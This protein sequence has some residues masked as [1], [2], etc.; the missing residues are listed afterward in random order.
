MADVDP[1][2]YDGP[3]RRKLD[4]VAAYVRAKKLVDGE[5]RNLIIKAAV[6]SF[7]A[8]VLV[9]IIVGLVSGGYFNQNARN[10]ALANC[11]VQADA[12]PT[13]NGRA[14]V[15]RQILEVADRAFQQFP[16]RF[17]DA[18]LARINRELRH[19][20]KNLG[21]AAPNVVRS[22]TDLGVLLQDLP[23]ITCDEI[24]R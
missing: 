22:F 1:T 14:F 23:L 7:I 17:R 15:S 9:G 24:I 3:E 12:R 5:I 11:H 20:R 8:A 19:D 16:E 18:E 10:N 2:P 13:G 4:E 21:P 6:A